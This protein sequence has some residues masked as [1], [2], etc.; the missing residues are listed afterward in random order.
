M[1]PFS[2]PLRDDYLYIKVY[3]KEIIARNEGLA[4]GNFQLGKF[5]EEAYE[6]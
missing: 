6:N 5:I 3:D 2:W 1:F 4:Y